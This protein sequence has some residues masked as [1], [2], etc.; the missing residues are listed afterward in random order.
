MK[1]ADYDYFSPLIF[2]FW[3]LILTGST[4]SDKCNALIGAIL[5]LGDLFMNRI[6]SLL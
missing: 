6:I 5:W 2:Q 4:F 1:H 3:A